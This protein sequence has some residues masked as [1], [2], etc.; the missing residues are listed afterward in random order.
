MKIDFP[1]GAAVGDIVMVTYPDSVLPIA[2]PGIC[3]GRIV[4]INGNKMKV[5]FIYELTFDPMEEVC[6]LNLETGIDET[7]DVPITEIELKV[8]PTR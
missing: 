5:H 7:Y 6:D 4:E 8:K 3:E 2:Q 1:E